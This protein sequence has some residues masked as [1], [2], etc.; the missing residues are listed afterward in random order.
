MTPDAVEPSSSLSSPVSLLKISL[1]DYGDVRIS[2]DDNAPVNEW[3][4]LLLYFSRSFS[5]NQL[6]RDHIEVPLI[7]FVDRVVWL[8]ENWM[9]VYGRESVDFSPAV[10]DAVAGARKGKL[11]F[12]SQ[13][14]LSYPDDVVDITVLSLKRQ[15]TDFQLRDLT[16]LM[17]MPNGANFSVPG[18]GKTSTTLALWALLRSQHIVEK[19]LVV[20]P[21]SA[22]ESWATEPNLLFFNPVRTSQFSSE[23][24]DASVEILYVN[25]E[26][27]E[28]DQRLTRLKKWVLWN[29]AML[30]IDEAHRVKA[31][32]RSIRWRACKAL[33]TVSKRTDLLTGTPLPHGH[34]DLRNLLRLSWQNLSNRDLSDSTLRMMKRGGVYVRTTKRELGL[35]PMEVSQV[36]I[37]MSTLQREIYSALRRNF[38]SIF[39][40]AAHEESFFARRGRAVMSLLAAA[41]NPGLLLKQDDDLA[42]LGLVWPPREITPGS[43]LM[44]LMQKYA[45]YEMP[46][47]YKWVTQHVANAH[48]A[49]RKTLIWSSFV[50]NLEAIRVALEK[51]GPAVIHGTVSPEDR[52]SELHRF[53]NDPNCA[54]LI[55]NP[56]T[57]GEG[58][59]LHEVCHEAIYLDR[60]FNAAHYLQSIDRIHRLGLR[61]EQVTKVFVLVTENSI[62]ESADR[63]LAAKIAR[64]GKQLDD[65]GLVQLSLPSGEDDEFSFTDYVDE[66]DLDELY[67]HLKDYVDESSSN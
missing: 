66:T 26:Q 3:Q 64:L 24:V 28:N 53:R 52:I 2:R 18:A 63:R 33:A 22:F 23:I 30:V 39:R 6:Q 8:R 44:K 58:I 31:G 36:M 55:T 1:N 42:F 20:C 62:D 29:D 9:R 65:E 32:S 21:R 59:N 14:V 5:G 41:S 27:L 57:L 10:V 34:E 40:I 7:D 15:L 67:S 19:L 50:G 35:P 51:F 48:S 54:V 61:P 45:R 4:A 60:S 43:E 25:Y 47:K 49:G 17:R 12:A 13:L 11:N 37:P 38:A 56:Q 16:A 46:P